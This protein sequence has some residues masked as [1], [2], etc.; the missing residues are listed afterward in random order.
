MNQTALSWPKVDWKNFQK[1]SLFLYREQSGDP[2]VEEFLRQGHFQAGIDLLSFVQSTGRHTCIQNKHSELSLAQLKKALSV[3]LNGTFAATAD[4]F[5]LTTTAD[6]QNQKIQQWINQQKILL[7]TQNGLAFDVWDVTRIEDM[8]KFQYR[9]V[10]KYFGKTEAK[11]H[12]LQ[13]AFQ[14][15]ELTSCPNF[16]ARHIQPL[17]DG[18]A[19]QSWD[20]GDKPRSVLTLTALLSVSGTQQKICL[21]AEAYEGKSSLFRQTAWE[22]SELGIGLAPLP[23][24][25]K[26]CSV[27]PIA[28]LLEDYYASWLSVPAKDIIVL[29]DGL[30][31]VPTEQFNTVVGHIRDFS[32]DHPAVRVAF[33]CRKLFYAYQHLPEELPGFGFY[34]LM[35]LH[36]GQLF[37]YLEAQ[38]NSRAAA[39]T[40]YSK[41][42][43][44][45]IGDLLTTPFYLIHLVSWF[46]DASREVPKTKIDVA[47]RFVDESLQ[48]SASRKIR[49]GLSLDKFSVHY[50]KLLQQLALLLQIKGVNACLDETLQDF[51]SQVDIDLLAHSSILNIRRNQWS[52][53][54]AFFQEQLAAL[55]LLNFDVATIICLITVGQ[56]IRKVS[57]K[58]IQTLAT[59]LSLLPENNTERQQL[60]A[61]IE[62]DNIELLALS[63]G[64]KFS[65]AFRLE[66]LQK[67]L[68]RA[69]RHQARLVAI[70]ES[71]LA[72]FAGN[73][74]AVVNE[75]I[76][77]LAADTPVIVKIVACRTLRYLQLTNTQAG[78]Y[79]VIA[80][81]QL[82]IE[83][84]SGLCRL[85]LEALAHYQMGDDLFLTE[86]L[87]RRSLLEMHE[88]R[89][90]LYR[91]FS[92]LELVDL[93]YNFLLEGFDVLYAH[94]QSTSHFG[95]ERRL[96]ELVLDTRE[97]RRIRQL[98]HLVQ[99]EPFQRFFRHNN[100]TIKEFYHNLATACAEI[101]QTDTAIIFPVVAYLIFTG[102]HNFD[103]EAN[104]MVEFLDKTN[105]FSLGLR[106]ALL[107]DK[108]AQQRYAFSGALRASCF[109]DILYAVEEGYIDRRQFAVF[110]SGFYYSGHQQEAE[111][112]EQLGVVLFDFKN[113]PD[114]KA[115]LYREAEQRKRQNDLYYISS[116]DAFREGI[117]K[118]YEHFGKTIIST[119]ELHERYDSDKPLL[120][121]NSDLV[122]WFLSEQADDENGIELERCLQALGDKQWFLTWRIDKLMKSYLVNY[123]PDIIR[124][125]L[126]AYYKEAVITF[127]FPAVNANSPLRDRRQA[128]QFL[129]IW[130]KYQFE[131]PDTVLLEFIRMNSEGFNGMHFAEVN[132][133]NSVTALLLEYFKDYPQL[134]KEKI[135]ANLQNGLSDAKVIGT[136]LEFCR[137]LRIRE[138]LPFILTYILDENSPTRHDDDFV[139]LYLDL[140]GSQAD[141]LPVLES[142]TDLNSYLFLHMVKLLGESYPDA[143]TAR[144][145]FCLN[146]GDTSAER[147][148][149]A[150]RRLAQLGNQE[151][152]SYIVAH[153]KP[154]QLAP[155]DIQ[156]NI[157]VWNV[158]T[159]WGL[160]QLS[161]LMPII[162]DDASE[163]MRFHH[164]P[165]YLLLEI[166]NGFAAKSEADL[167]ITTTFMNQ[168][169]IQL[170]V[171]H[172]KKAGHLGWHAEQMTERYR[173]SDLVII[174]DRVIKRLFNQIME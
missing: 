151:G 118:L 89:Q 14:L 143:V 94:N 169:A 144:L 65:P 107:S 40:F 25:L 136:H 49:A 21:V 17:A 106:I 29:I 87:Q 163:Q 81:R 153:L 63:E 116:P 155:F 102:R 99:S 97:P 121:V 2:A 67:I 135:L 84:E 174:S 3:F 54:N 57:K 64:S 166:L 88:F 149:E 16:I 50:K 142:I 150:A 157:A 154:G 30:D 146:A 38:L 75:L 172:P 145:L 5:I 73:S 108:T 24:D 131:T 133:R 6:L 137:V 124:E 82:L 90:G 138:A 98:F 139:N 162:L 76:G 33:S 18:P 48:L 92:R 52:F 80:K 61:V 47:R 120:E 32:R 126:D 171:T 165:K 104:E 42:N 31:E 35:D 37:A 83:N 101:Y 74:D 117:I 114:P 125:H 113:E 59:Y 112:L 77:V 7:R 147:K 115:L 11:V 69:N 55:A 95:S 62:A 96:L 105:T 123:F 51:F 134:I 70:D 103:R 34:E 28:R 12:C 43:G 36:H 4:I 158:P 129:K 130:E 53:M 173:Q 78:R 8:L 127:P 45:G 156:G 60:I 66:V 85:L 72:T 23:L 109:E 9:L 20:F 26:F 71:N 1:I 44:L 160:E 39:M 111:Q 79:S 161:P 152:F 132:K 164:S 41:M 110:G 56:N 10:E 140:G 86:L 46:R 91:Y 148:M 141:L 168:C 15:P 128:V 58:W 19:D 119:E 93:Y 22:L 27:L 122:C 167:E 68:Q 159:V 13:P 170:G 100:D